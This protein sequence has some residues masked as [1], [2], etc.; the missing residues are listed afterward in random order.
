LRI[1]IDHRQEQ[2]PDWLGIAEFI[3]NNKVYSSTKTLL[4]K[5]D[6]GQDP[7]M[8]FEVKR[9]GKYKGI[10]KFVIKIR[11]VQEKAKAVLEKA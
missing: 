8:G 10:E 11:K 5:T 3:Y 6:Y 9:K 1:F 4:F 7:R 2:W